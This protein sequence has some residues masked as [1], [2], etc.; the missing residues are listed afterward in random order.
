MKKSSMMAPMTIMASVA[1]VL[2]LSSAAMASAAGAAGLDMN[3][4]GSTCP[5]VEAIVKEE[6]VAI[7]KAAPT[8]AGPLLRLHFHDCFV[9][10]YI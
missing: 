10:V 2:V 3:F 8:L 5:R 4:Y 1:A 7:L 6:M 9:R